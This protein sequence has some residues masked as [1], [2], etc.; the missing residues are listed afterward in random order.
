MR[1]TCITFLEL[2]NINEMAQS[3]YLNS[4]E[5]FRKILGDKVMAKKPNTVTELWK[6]LLEEW[7]K[8]T[9]AVCEKLV[10][11]CGRRCAEAIQSKGLYTSY[12][13]LTAV[14]FRNFICNLSSCY[15]HCCTLILITVFHKIK[16]FCWSALVYIITNKGFKRGV[17]Y[18]TVILRSPFSEQFLKGPFFLVWRTFNNP[19][20]LFPL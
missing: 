10:M 6:R 5:N 1:V 19:K 20:N 8:I 13:F 4:T 17:S 2:E 18:A 14:A 3:L 11:S 15:S 9:P 12:L 16:H 7:T